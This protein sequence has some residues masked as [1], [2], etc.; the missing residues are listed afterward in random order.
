MNCHKCRVAFDP[1]RK[2][3]IAGREFNC[4][5]IKTRCPSCN[6]VYYAFVDVWTSEEMANKL[7][8]AHRK[9]ERTK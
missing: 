8:E 2:A 7:I 5:E 6:A 3:Y 1:A 9:K 4:L